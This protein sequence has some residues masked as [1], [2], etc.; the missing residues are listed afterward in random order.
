M[1]HNESW[2]SKSFNTVNSVIILHALIVVITI[3]LVAPTFA[4]AQDDVEV[5]NSATGS[6]SSNDN[7]IEMSD[8]A[9]VQV[10]SDNSVNN[11]VT[12]NLNTGNNN[13]LGNTV[14]GDVKTGAIGVNIGI[15]NKTKSPCIACL[16]QLNH[17][18][19]QNSNTSNSI[20]GA[21]SANSNSISVTTDTNY[22]V[23]S[24]SDV[25]NVVNITANTG[26]NATN[27]NTQVGTNS[28]GNIF[29]TVKINNQVDKTDKPHVNNPVIPTVPNNVIPYADIPTPLL[30]S[31][32][33]TRFAVGGADLA[34]FRLSKP[35][36]E[37]A[38]FPAG[39][40]SSLA[41][42][43]LIITIAAVWYGSVIRHRVSSLLSGRYA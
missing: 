23:K 22:I 40:G 1:G 43:N 38:F 12:L 25:K 27:K 19:E 21:Q 17:D 15:T 36:S 42:F 11:T 6:L 28:T 34:V 24:H 8:T 2:Y 33:P 9:K 3:S 29:A 16:N 30:R 31:S 39:G 41:L 13:V 35:V 7:T 32:I 4:N 37:G 18:K 5:V 14:V 26:N 10:D 20:T